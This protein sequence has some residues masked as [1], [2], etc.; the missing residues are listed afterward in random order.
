MNEASLGFAAVAAL[1]RASTVRVHDGAR[2][3][4]CG[5]VW[6]ADGSIVTNAHVARGRVAEIEFLDGRRERGEVVR[7]DDARDLAAVRLAPRG[8][9][10]ARV[11]P[12]RSLAPG[13]LVVAIGSPLGLAHACSAGIV[14]RRNPRWVVAD[15]KLAPGNSGGPLADVTGRVVGINSMV[16][17]GLGYAVPSEAVAAF[18]EGRR[19]LGI[20]AVRGTVRRG[21]RAL[22]A[23]VVTDIEPG[24]VADRAGLAVGDAI[25]ATDAALAIDGPDE[26]LASLSRADRLAILRAGREITLALT[27][28]APTREDADAA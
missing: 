27:W 22:P 12:A 17:N 11:R 10:P 15:V 2:G 13:E 6:G 24:G 18:L 20:S 9:E 3:S 28:P 7:R 14:Q 23:I 25:Y 21:S 8:L 19:R 5:I 1:L 16:V 4:G 26:L